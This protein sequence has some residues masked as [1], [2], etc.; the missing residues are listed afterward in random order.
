MAGA[1]KI[2]DSEG[3]MLLK[4]EELTPLRGRLYVLK[5][6]E[7]EIAKNLKIS[8]KGVYGVKR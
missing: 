2:K 8:E 5:P 1:I 3:K 4:K 7:S 6:A